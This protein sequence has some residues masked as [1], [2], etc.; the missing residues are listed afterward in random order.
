MAVDFSLTDEQQE[1][2]RV[3]HEFA[4]REI[5]PVAA[6]YDESE[7]MPW[8][9][10]ERAAGIGLLSYGLPDEYGGGGVSDGIVGITNFVVTEELAWGCAAIATEI[11]SSVYAAGPIL[12]F[13][14]DEQRRRWLPRF[15]ETERVR[16]GA[17][18]LTEPQAGSDISAIET[19][20]RREGDEWVIDGRKQFITNGGIAD[21]HVVFA[22]VDGERGMAPFVVEEGTPGLEIGRKERKLGMRAS[23]TAEIVLD[24]CRIPDDNRLGG[25]LTIRSPAAEAAKRH[26]RGG[27]L[28][29]AGVALTIL[30]YS[31]M[32]FAAGALGVARAAF[33]YARDYA[34]ERPAFGVPIARHQAVSFKLADM[35]MEIEAARAL[36]WRAGWLATS[37]RPLAL[38]EGSM[39]KCMAGDVAVRC[40]TE[41]VQILG[42]HG[43]V[44]D[45]P[46][47]KWYRY[48]KLYQI[49]EGT[50]EIQRLVIARALLG[51]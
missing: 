7:E 40:C 27:S 42:G 35:A 15:C 2:Q 24:G 46:V 11:G 23:H 25:E 9:V 17:L 13:G 37:G 5:R 41:A 49:W 39:A 48:A 43:Y 32:S 20:A 26:A 44:K 38:A 16:L 3:A 47:E 19:R 34:K 21:I 33:E 22:K 30:Q 50:N 4:R 29:G 12:A 51:D 45:H 31:R 36:L 10:L 6:S 28:S 14:T 1:M 18:C 8:P